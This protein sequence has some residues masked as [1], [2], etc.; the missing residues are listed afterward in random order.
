MTSLMAV[1]TPAP[2]DRRWRGDHNGKTPS[3][4]VL[5]PDRQPGDARRPFPHQKE[6]EDKLTERLAVW[7]LTGQLEGL[8]VMPTGSG[9]TYCMVRW[10][11]R[12]VVDLKHKILWLA[13]NDMLL[14]QAACTFHQLIGLASQ[15]SRVA[16]R[17]V[18]GGHCSTEQIEPSD[19]VILA[20]VASLHRHRNVFRGLL[21]D[22]RVFVVVDEAHH[23][24]AT[25]YRL[26]LESLPQARR[27]VGLTATA[28][29]TTPRERPVLGHLFGNSI[30]SQADLE[31]LIERRILSPG[32][33]QGRDTI[34]HRLSDRPER[35]EK[36]RNNR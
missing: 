23:A 22:P 1:P 4:A 2:E 32:L 6:A 21:S 26:L 15:R 17:I 8:V 16:I 12:Q 5:D 35:T 7:K 30:I 33:D 28:T 11:V 9:K 3:F 36:P 20:S 25:S 18:S 29:R 31:S 24:P 10:L 19:D 34:R 27:V 13:P 14:E